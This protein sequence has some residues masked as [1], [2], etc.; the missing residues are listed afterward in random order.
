VRSVSGEVLIDAEHGVPLKA[1]LEGVV[2]YSQNGTPSE[3]A[4]KISY[5]ISD[6]GG[7][8]AVT[9]PAAED[10]VD[11]PVRLREV[12]ERDDL[13]EGIAP[14]A[15]KSKAKTPSG[16]AKPAKSGAKK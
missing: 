10:T 16:G 1:T 4:I 15:A 13:L 12:D 7:A 11:T 9:A 8:V 3:M 5:D 14:P 2:V 6:I